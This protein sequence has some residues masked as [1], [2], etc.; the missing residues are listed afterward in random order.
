MTAEVFSISQRKATGYSTERK[1]GGYAPL[2]AA[3]KTA[4]G[5]ASTVREALDI[6]SEA[7]K[8]D[9]VVAPNQIGRATSVLS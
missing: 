5:S 8:A 3:D 6:C 9:H 7:V 4:L 1:K 2:S